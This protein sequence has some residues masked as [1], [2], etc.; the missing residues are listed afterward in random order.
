[1]IKFT[2]RLY[3]DRSPQTNKLSSLFEEIYHLYIRSNIDYGNLTIIKIS[4]YNIISCIILLYILYFIATTK[5]RRRV[6]FRGKNCLFTG[7]TPKKW[8]ILYFFG[9]NTKKWVYFVIFRKKTKNTSFFL[10][11]LGKS[12]LHEL[13][14][15]FVGFTSHI[16]YIKYYK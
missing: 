11:F 14:C 16:Y 7:K 2:I 8:I 9:K 13:L 5:L 15:N 4:I 1:M 10:C 3:S 12:K 6:D